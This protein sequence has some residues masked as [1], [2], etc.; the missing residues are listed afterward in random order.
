MNFLHNNPLAVMAAVIS[1]VAGVATV[2]SYWL[3]S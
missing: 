1:I 2:L 3:L